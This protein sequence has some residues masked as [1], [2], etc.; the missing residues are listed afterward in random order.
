MLRV[1]IG[2][3]IKC[4]MG[5]WVAQSIKCLILDFMSGHDPNVK[6][7]STM[8]GWVLSRSLL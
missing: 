7:L 6:G 8:L 3:K 4:Q 2:S 5:A 1:N